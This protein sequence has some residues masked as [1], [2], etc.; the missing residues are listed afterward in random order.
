MNEII[1]RD[2]QVGLATETVRG[3]AATTVE[4][5]MRNVSV[6]ILERAEHVEDDSRRGVL[7]DMQGR[8]VIS[9]YIEGDIEGI[10]HVDAIGYLYSSIYGVVVSEVVA[11]SVYDHEF[12]L[13]QNIEHPTLTVF[14]K[15]G[16]AQQ[17]K[18]NGCVLNTLEISASID[19][20]V[21]FTAGIIGI[22]GVDNAAVP[23]YDTE[24]DFI[25]RD[26]TIKV[27]DSE[28][29]LS[30][31]TAIKAKSVSINHDQGAIRDQVFGANTP[32]NIYNAKQ[33]IDGEFMLNFTDETFKDLYLGNTSKYMSIT[34]EG[35]ADLGSGNKPTIT[36]IFNNIMITDWTRDG[37]SDEL[38]T[39]TVSFKAYYNETDGE[40]SKVTLRN[41][42]S[43]YSDVPSS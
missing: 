4:K 2:L 34:I 27:A 20:F 19:N 43:S 13:G 9:K 28:A 15:D 11:G 37:G 5:W 32:D 30:G 29:G 41:L 31:A 10:V 26:I 7:E 6:S 16:D 8:R 38:V 3:T 18:F 25:G 35:E 39:Q 36:Y 22:G 24:Y 1:G 40:A 33:S 42:T 21:R 14:A 23:D 12:T 17:L